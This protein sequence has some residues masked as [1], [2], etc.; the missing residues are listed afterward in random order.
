MTGDEGTEVRPV[1]SKS[2]GVFGA[3]VCRV[4]HSLDVHNIERMIIVRPREPGGAYCYRTP[5]SK[6]QPRKRCGHPHTFVEQIRG[7]R[8]CKEG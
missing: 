2:K 7:S 6:E 8:P 4:F 1:M 3:E 5:H